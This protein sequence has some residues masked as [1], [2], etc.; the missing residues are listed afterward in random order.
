[1]VLPLTVRLDRSTSPEG[2][3]IY[4]PFQLLQLLWRLPSATTLR[5]LWICAPLVQLLL[6]WL[7][8]QLN[9][10]LHYSTIR[11]K[12]NPDPIDRCMQR[13]HPVYFLHTRIYIINDV[14]TFIGNT[15][16]H[17]L[18]NCSHLLGYYTIVIKGQFINLSNILCLWGLFPIINSCKDVDWR[19]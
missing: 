16:T 11:F 19:I 6:H 1:M 3:S 8:L 5:R 15:L 13:C 4:L 17:Y 7:Q 2:W 10:G 9:D 12:C 18:Q 14:G